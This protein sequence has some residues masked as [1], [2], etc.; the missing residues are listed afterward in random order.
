MRQAHSTIII[1]EVITPLATPLYIRFRRS[2]LWLIAIAALLAILANLFS[3]EFAKLLI[4][5]GFWQESKV[6]KGLL[7]DTQESTPEVVL[8][9]S[10]R[11]QN[12]FNTEYFRQNGHRVFN[13]GAPGILPWD[14]PFMVGQA[15]K[16]AEKTVVISI[17]AEILLGAVGCPLRWTLTD[18]A[19]YA[20]QAPT[21]LRGLSLIEWL[22][23]LPINAF[24]SETFPDVH[25]DP[26]NE[27]NR[28]S[29]LSELQAARG[30]GLCEDARGLMLLRYSRRWV[31]VFRNGDGLIIPDNYPP[32]QAQVTWRDQQEADLQPTV[33]RFLN[34]L[35]DRV[36]AENKTPIFVV[37]AA[38]LEH[39]R[40][41]HGIIERETGART[42]YMNELGFADDEI[43]DHDHVGIKGNA[44]LSKLL[45]E[46]LFCTTS[47][48]SEKGCP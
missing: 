23:P 33:L 8:V 5:R 11:V 1:T 14:F 47:T 39:L 41:P 21:C 34:G 12:H 30:L 48:S 25:Y 35:A 32:R 10:S 24:F 13:L 29:P 6:W 2:V 17:P 40:I 42:L 18:M 16:A 15:A 36:R 3:V 7:L 37:E 20:K 45:F 38:P 22:E 44:R 27:N 28:R 9:G 4:Q 19:F 26:C 46:Q 43:A 31:A